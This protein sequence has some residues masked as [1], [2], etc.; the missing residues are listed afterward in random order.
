MARALESFTA[1][2]VKN[3]PGDSGGTIICDPKWHA[4]RIFRAALAAYTAGQVTDGDRRNA[5]RLAFCCELGV[6]WVR[7]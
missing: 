1:Y 3:Y 4:P 5:E 6:F 7:V 2:F